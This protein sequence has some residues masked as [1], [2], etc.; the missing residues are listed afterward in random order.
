M[1]EFNIHDSKVEQLNDS[2][3][4]YKLVSETGSNVVSEKGDVVLT[5]GTGHKVQVDRP[6][7]FWSV[8]WGKIRSC[9]KWL[10]G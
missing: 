7:G 10:G 9:W 2:G 6:K 3:N 1:T 8:V 5:S 4:N